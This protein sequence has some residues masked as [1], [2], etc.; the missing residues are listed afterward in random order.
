M[1]AYRNKQAIILLGASNLANAFPRIISLLEAGLEWPLETLVAM[2]HGRS[3]GNWSK[4]LGRTLPGINACGLWEHTLRKNGY[5]TRP[6]AAITDL[7]NDLMYGVDAG[8]LLEWLE[9]TLQRLTAIDSRIVMLS[10]P[11]QSLGRMTPDRFNLAR[12]IIFPGHQATWAEVQDQIIRLDQG[13]RELS[14]RHETAWVEAEPEWYGW[15]T[16]HITR[17]RQIEAWGKVFSQWPEWRL[18]EPPT[19]PG[20]IGSLSIRQLRP[21]ERWLFGRHQITPQPALCK[22]EHQ[23]FIF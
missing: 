23:V 13:M 8:M 20:L 11:T 10:L 1:D 19:I 6:L 5:P 9:T 16:I 15:D 7:G 12:R 17:P 2:G 22:P 4:L 21:A 14:R 3:Y 18:S